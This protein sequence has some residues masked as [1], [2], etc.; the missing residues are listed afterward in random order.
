M[1]NPNDAI[2]IKHL[3]SLMAATS[4]KIDA[5][6]FE[7]FPPS[8]FF[9]GNILHLDGKEF[10][11]TGLADGLSIQDGVFFDK[12]NLQ[13][14]SVSSFHFQFT[15]DTAFDV[16]D[17]DTISLTQISGD[18]VDY[19]LDLTF[20]SESDTTWEEVDGGYLYTTGSPADYIKTG[21]TT[22][23][24][25]NTS[26]S[27]TSSTNIF[28]L[29]GIKTGLLTNGSMPDSLV[30]VDTIRDATTGALTSVTFTI[31]NA[32]L[33]DSPTGS[34]NIYAVEDDGN[35]IPANVK[36]GSDV[37]NLGL[38]KTVATLEEGSDGIYTYTDQEYRNG[39]IEED[40]GENGATVVKYNYRSKPWGG[41]FCTI[42]GLA[43][44]LTLESS[45]N[46][47]FN[48]YKNGSIVGKIKDAT[49]TISDIAAIDTSHGFVSLTDTDYSTLHWSWDY[50]LVLD[51]SLTKSDTVFTCVHENNSYSFTI[52]KPQHFIDNGR[53]NI[54]GNEHYWS[55]SF[56]F[57]PAEVKS[58]TIEGLP[59]YGDLDFDANGNFGYKV[60]TSLNSL[61]QITD[62]LVSIGNR[63]V[64]SDPSA[65]DRV[66]FSDN[67]DNFSLEFA[68]I[69]SSRSFANESF[70]AVAA[71]TYTYT[72]T[73]S[74]TGWQTDPD[75]TQLVW[76]TDLNG[77]SFTLNNLRTDLGN[78]GFDSQG[79]I[80]A[81]NGSTI[82]KLVGSTITLY[83]T[84]VHKLA[85][86]YISGTDASDF[87][88]VLPD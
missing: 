22:Y 64:L 20:A 25:S 43:S 69:S 86:P 84:A 4:E 71:G 48:I 50:R 56:S 18:S 10:Q 45:T 40:S 29:D 3:E 54:D 63:A 44:G 31:M 70:S 51:S 38:K 6:Y 59:N 79:N 30:G 78:L 23:T 85:T 68:N 27:Y 37:T 7:I 19:S 65:D 77:K 13:V 87:T 67:P 53:T 8:D 55:Q 61:G 5:L 26:G 47:V 72:A 81:T 49:I 15:T 39:Y 16:D 88:L 17:G 1:D 33:P 41:D 35:P 12:N 36:L 58:F 80:H 82:G 21:D 74:T 34:T 28:W 14:G 9:E 66:F 57:V 75:G 46:G 32:T 60:E 11:F 83:D 42:E 2:R 52:T 24:K 76:K 73:G 62:N